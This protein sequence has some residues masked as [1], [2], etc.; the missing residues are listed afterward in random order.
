M[1][2]H[3]PDPPHPRQIDRG[4]RGIAGMLEDELVIGFIADF[5]RELFDLSC[6]RRT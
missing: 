2:A 3:N 4:L 6:R 1:P 5:A